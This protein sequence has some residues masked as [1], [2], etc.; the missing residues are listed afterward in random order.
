MYPAKSD[1]D[2]RVISGQLQEQTA[3]TTIR[4]HPIIGEDS[5]KVVQMTLLDDKCAFHLTLLT[6]DLDSKRY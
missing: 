3:Q 6:S 2:V 1:E 4:W 5:I